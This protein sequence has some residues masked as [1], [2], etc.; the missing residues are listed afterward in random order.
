M[1]I[2][3]SGLLKLFKELNGSSLTYI[4]KADNP[5]LIIAVSDEISKKQNVFIQK[6]NSEISE[7]AFELSKLSTLDSQNLLKDYFPDSFINPFLL[8]KI[9]G[10]N[11][12]LIDISNHNKIDLD[13]E[14]HLK[15]L[16]ETVS[17]Q[18]KLSF[19][20][21][22]KLNLTFSKINAVVY[23]YN[24]KTKKYDFISSSIEKVLGLTEEDLKKKKMSL[25]RRIPKEFRLDYK[26]FLRKVTHGESSS[27][28]FQYFNNFGHRQFLHH[29]AEPILN[30][31]GRIEK[32]V[33]VIND[34]SREK[35][36]LHKLS[37][38]EKRFG[39][40]INTAIDFIYSLNGFGYLL[41][42]NENGANSLGYKSEEMLGMHFLDFAAEDQ[43]NQIS[44]S[45]QKMLSSKQ[46][47]HFEIDLQHKLNKT[48]KYEFLATPLIEGDTIT[49]M[50][51][52]GRDVSRRRKNEEEIAN[53]NQKLKES[54]RLVEIERDRAKQQITILEEI[55]ILKNEFIAN[56]SH[57]LRTPLASIVGFAETLASDEDLPKDLVSEFSEIIFTEG[58][59]LAR[60]IEDILDFSELESG[61]ANLHKENLNIIELMKTISEKVKEGFET[62]NIS[63]TSLIPEAEITIFADREKLVKA[64]TTIF[65]NTL[66]FTKNG[67]Q[68]SVVIQDFLKEVEITISDN[69]SGISENELELLFDKFHSS[70]STSSA[71][72]TAGIALSLVKQIFDHH[73]GLLQV[74]SNLGEGTTFIIR[75]PKIFD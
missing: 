64:F 44:K 27:I 33:G 62:A 45:F 57:E 32:I 51:G 47:V 24:L 22:E 31:N 23:S 65:E 6:F 53:L 70:G 2:D 67:D 4:L 12:Y 48:I 16:L 60:F 73:K 58:K 37:K 72:P 71:T 56:V 75:L 66:R 21:H 13:E 34:V 19:D 20:L 8:C 74:K 28:D 69:G 63:F 17:T 49:G 36:I 43:K 61:G 7:A 18:L 41:Q 10:N 52:I 40:L 68:V 50:L 46:T 26:N 29:A 42:V 5:D 1:D 30:S 25:I 15:T 35:E 54:Q 9:E 39:L 38:S 14:P 3:F 55:N 11:Y 59:R